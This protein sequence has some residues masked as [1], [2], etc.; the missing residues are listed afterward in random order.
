MPG[1]WRR[2]LEWWL[3]GRLTWSPPPWHRPIGDAGRWLA[4]ESDRVRQ[5]HLELSG[6]YP[7]ERW[8]SLCNAVEYRLS[9][10]VL[11]L[12]DRRLGPAG[13]GP[14]LDIGSQDFAYLPGLATWGGGPWH[15][16]ELEPHRRRWTLATRRAHAERLC[17]AFPGA[18]YHPGS[19]LELQGEFDA[20][21]WFLPFVLP[22]PLRAR[23][24]PERFFQPHELLTHAHRLLA[25]GGRM[26]VVNQ[27]EEEAAEQARLFEALAIDARPIGRLDGPFSPYRQPRFGWLVER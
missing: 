1:K 25:P 19:L 27:G 16:V 10:H 6:R 17:R 18:R 5:R 26:L 4:G 9:L 21:T 15:G 24:L 13:R 3:Q 22:A 11:D 20:V 14:A 12:L 8:P 23:G 2:E 7:L